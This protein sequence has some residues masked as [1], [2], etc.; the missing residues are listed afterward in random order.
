MK[1]VDRSRKLFEDALKEPEEF[2][3]PDQGRSAALNNFHGGV[4]LE[5]LGNG[6]RVTGRDARDQLLWGMVASK[7]M[8]E[9][10]HCAVAIYTRLRE[11]VND[12]IASEGLPSL[13][14]NDAIA[15]AKQSLQELHELADL[16]VKKLTVKNESES[17]IER[18][19]AIHR[20]VSDAVLMIRQET[21]VVTRGR[22]PVDL[23]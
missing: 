5:R 1:N 3:A 13:P 9:Q 8:I 21:S 14:P 12:A 11:I 23:D 10:P 2:S 22:H 18:A 17:T 4:V 6:V 15:A 16:L 19:A 7:G 20:A